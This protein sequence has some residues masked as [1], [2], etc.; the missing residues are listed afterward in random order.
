MRARC[1]VCVGLFC[2][3]YARASDWS[4]LYGEA[5]LAREKPRL[6]H[7]AEEVA[8][9]EIGP[10]FNN[11]QRLVFGVLPIDLPLNTDSASPIEGDLHRSGVIVLPTL[12]LLFVED[13]AKAYAWL[14]SN[15]LSSET[16][17]EYVSMLRYRR[18]SDFPDGKY[19]APAAALHVPANALDNADAK[20]M[21]V[22]LRTSAYMF[23]IL[24][25]IGNLRS[26][27][28]IAGEQSDPF[29]LDLMKRNS[30]TPLGLLLLMNAGVYL[31]DEPHPV[32]A[33]RLLAMANYLDFHIL[34][35]VEARPDRVAAR[36][37][38]H[39]IAKDFRVLAGSL[40]D[41]G[42]QTTWAERARRTDVSTLLPKP[43]PRPR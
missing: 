9:N 15:R 36:N 10:Y 39:A 33:K 34:E 20:K 37:A 7:L 3:A 29:A 38:I 12:T 6:Q 41:P 30:E 24:H 26:P 11:G 5:G 21:F 27:G 43:Q 42:T 13:L 32:T 4:S 25:Q 23:L 18:P 22:R 14:W 2:A 16:V 19:P 31:P 1:L 35:F 17:D 28:D 40:D 8:A